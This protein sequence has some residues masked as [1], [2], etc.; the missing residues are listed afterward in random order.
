M[1]EVLADGD[2]G[3]GPQ[4]DE[5]GAT[6]AARLDPQDWFALHAILFLVGGVNLVMINWAHSSN[7]WWVWIPVTAWLG[8]L[9]AHGVWVL[10][11]GH[12]PSPPR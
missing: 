4:R 11:S 5:R 2:W 3:S 9:A 8:V 10:L 7:G 6:N 1:R 12:R